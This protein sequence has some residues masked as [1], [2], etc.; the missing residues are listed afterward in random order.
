[1]RRNPETTANVATHPSA[2]PFMARIAASP[3]EEPSSVWF[4]LSGFVETL[5]YMI[6][7]LERKKSPWDV[8]FDERDATRLSDKCDE[9]EGRR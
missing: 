9:L 1:M 4:M 6:H 7:A 8:G 2:A 3:P 5:P